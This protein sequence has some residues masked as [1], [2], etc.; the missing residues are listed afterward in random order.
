MPLV[1][2]SPSTQEFNPY[3]DGMG[4]E[5]YY[6]NLI[7]DCMIPY[8]DASDIAWRRNT[9]EDTAQT[10][11]QNS[12]DV[13][14]DLH[15]AIHSNAAPEELSGKLTG[16]DVYYYTTSE[17]GRRAAT[18]FANNLQMIYPNPGKVRTVPTTGLA[19]LRRTK[20]PAIL[21][22][23][24]YHDNRDDANWIRTNIRDIAKNLSE[25]VADYFAVPF[26]QP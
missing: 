8:L 18:I 5:E 17:N 22:E 25:S 7:A 21:I 11:A 16:T 6:M 24:A 13:G 4:S 23:L 19:E 12:N 3:Y 15:V 1:Y 14:A 10:S 2:L 9:P 20:A 26:V